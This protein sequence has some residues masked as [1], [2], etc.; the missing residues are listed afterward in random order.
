MGLESGAVRGVAGS[1]VTR[2]LVP[3][4]LCQVLQPQEVR[5]GALSFPDF[6]S[7]SQ[8]KAALVLHWPFCSPAQDL[9]LEVVVGVCPCPHAS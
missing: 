1:W 5:K 2:T 8:K 3:A 9:T 7:T 6:V 4:G